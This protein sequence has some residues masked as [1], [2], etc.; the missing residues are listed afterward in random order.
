[1]MIARITEAWAAAPTP[2]RKRA[3]ISAPW[4]GAMP[5]EQ[6]RGGE[7]G[8]AG[9]EHALAP[10]E[11]A[12]PAGQQQQAAEGDEE[13]VDDPGEIGL[14]EVE[15]VLDRGQRDVHDRH[16][17]HDHQ[18]GEADDEQRRPA[19]A[20]GWKSGERLGS[21]GSKLVETV[22]SVLKWRPPPKYLEAPSGNYTEGPSVCQAGLHEHH[23]NI[24][25]DAARRARSAPTRG[26]TTR[27]SWRPRA[28]RSPRAVSRR[29]SRRSPAAPGWGSA[30]CT[31]TSPTGRRCSRRST[32]TRSRRCAARPPSSTAPIRGR[33]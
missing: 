20:V 12:E 3:P 16:V 8:E 22:S 27:R 24:H 7:D 30:R 26:A 17:E 21:C 1:M 13:R 18:L 2:C 31:A 14:A 6:R 4:L 32:S 28:R 15:V 10:G 25:R 5:H 23:R 19:A 33:R 29:R 11:V 9:E